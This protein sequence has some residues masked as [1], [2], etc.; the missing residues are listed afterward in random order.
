MNHCNTLI[1]RDSKLKYVNLNSPA[2]TIK[3]LIKLHKSDQPIRPVVNWRNAPAYKLSQLLTTKITQFSSLPYAFNVRNTTELIRQLK[4]IPTTPTSMSASLNITNMYSNIPV[5]ETKQILENILASGLTDHKVSS[6][7]LNCYEVVT[8]QNYFTHGDKIIT[9]TDGLA[10]GTPS[11]GIISGIFLQHFQHSHLPR[12]AH[13]HNLV[14][15]FRYVYNVLLTFEH[16]THWHKR[17]P[18][19]LQLIPPQS[20]I[21]WRNRTKQHTPLPGHNYPQNTDWCEHSCF[22][23]THIQ[24][25]YYSVYLQ[26]PYPTQICSNQ[27]PV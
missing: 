25:H 8:K 7:I 13:K 14:N 2:P 12:L 5:S 10:M 16:A 24:W 19:W 27:I 4:Q 26:P 22:Q 21:H 20:A 6:E 23:E 1:P 11:S 15:H 18:R 3:G 17:N 9:K